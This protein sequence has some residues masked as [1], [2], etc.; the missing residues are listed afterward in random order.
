MIAEDWGSTAAER[1]V[2]YPAQDALGDAEVVMHRA[3]DVDAPPAVVFRWLCQIRV[4]PY[5]Y[6]LVDNLG[7]RSPRTLRPGLEQLEVGQVFAR[8][9]RLHSFEQDR[10]LTITGLGVAM[11]YAVTPGRL[12]GVL[13]LPRRTWWTT[14]L[15][16][17]D[18][19]MMRKQLLTLKALAERTASED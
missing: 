14:P 2:R 1:A 16:I 6:D 10:W 3:V 19:V 13:A 8:A 11:T 7:K 18:L 9:F 17:G 5:S 15:A 12:I 4:S